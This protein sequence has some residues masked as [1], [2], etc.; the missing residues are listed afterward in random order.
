MDD[1]T[2]YD[3]RLE[4]DETKNDKPI[5][6]TDGTQNNKSIKK[7][8]DG[9]QN[10]KPIKKLIVLSSAIKRLMI[11]PKGEHLVVYLNNSKM[12]ICETKK[13][14]VIRELELKK[15]NFRS[16]VTKSIG[17]KYHYR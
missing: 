3:A 15:D 4:A 16:L 7:L 9:T 5:K 13:Y 1:Y 14:T 11:S 8:S 17:L 12:L 2:D 10:D 6:L